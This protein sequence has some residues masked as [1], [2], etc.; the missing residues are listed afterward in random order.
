MTIPALGKVAEVTQ[1][2]M[3]ALAPRRPQRLCG[4]AAVPSGARRALRRDRAYGRSRGRPSRDARRGRHRMVQIKTPEQIA[5]MREAGLVV[6]AIHAATRE[7]AVPGATTKDLDEVAAQGDRRPRR[8]VELPGLRRLPRD[9]LHLGQ[10][11]RGARHPGPRDRAA[12]TAT[13]SPSTRRDHRRLARRRR[14]HRLRRRRSRAGAARAQPGDRGV[15]VGRHRRGAARA[16]GW[17]TSPRRSRATSAASRAR[18]PA[19]TG[20]SRTTAATASAAEMHMDPHLLNYVSTQARQG[21]EAGARLL[22]RDRADGDAWAPRKT[23]GPRRRLDGHDGRRHLVLA[24][25]ALGR[26]D[27]G[28]PAGADRP[29][30]R[31]GEAGRARASRPAPDPLARLERPRRGSP[32]RRRR[33]P[34]RPASVARSPTPAR[35]ITRRIRLSRSGR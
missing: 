35:W 8:Q 23:A 2:A 10:R 19:S 13:S 1:R 31:Q 24:L 3:D 30:R 12:R 18:R 25:G 7:A 27:R 15:D 16:T 4:T 21:P 32:R 14:L 33:C 22:P 5:K 9:H 20:S 11:R 17:S 34:G 28:G 26:A 29:G 6:A